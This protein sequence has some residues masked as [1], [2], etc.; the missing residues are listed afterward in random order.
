MLK[1]RVIVLLSGCLLIGLV[2]VLLF[3]DS[4]TH[5]HKLENSSDQSAPSISKATNEEFVDANY[6]YN[7]LVDVTAFS[8]NHFE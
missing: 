6:L 7:H 3:S 5:R 4:I 8:D 2:S 1:L